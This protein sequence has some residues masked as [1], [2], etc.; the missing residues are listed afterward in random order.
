MGEPKLVCPDIFVTLANH[1]NKFPLFSAILSYRLPTHEPCSQLIEIL[2]Q[3]LP[4]WCVP[5]VVLCSLE[6]GEGKDLC[7]FLL[8]HPEQ[9]GP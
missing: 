2:Q 6:V 1:D 7:Q 4:C 5:L 9:P 8:A 3:P